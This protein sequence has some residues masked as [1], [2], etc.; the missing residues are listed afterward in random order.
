MSDDRVDRALLDEAIRIGEIYSDRL[1]EA[2][3]EIK[4]LRQAMWSAASQL[5]RG[6]ADAARRA[7]EAEISASTRRLG[8]I[9]DRLV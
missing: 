5:R 4:H 2:A 8:D 9:T 6:N 3:V 7:L 1:I